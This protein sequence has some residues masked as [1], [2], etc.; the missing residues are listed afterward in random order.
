[1]PGQSRGKSGSELQKE[2]TLR[3]QEELRDTYFNLL[4]DI[5]RPLPEAPLQ[6]AA[7]YKARLREL[8]PLVAENKSEETAKRRHV[9]VRTN[10]HR[11]SLEQNT[12]T[13]SA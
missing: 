4:R 3:K 8:H 12:C 10:D 7:Q 5:R 6:P 2:A 9:A 13:Q 1:M 11:T